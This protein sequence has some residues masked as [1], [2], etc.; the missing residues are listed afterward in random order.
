M[1]SNKYQKG[2]QVLAAFNTV[3]VIVMTIH[4]FMSDGR[5]ITRILVF[6]KY[7]ENKISV[8][9]FFFPKISYRLQQRTPKCG[10]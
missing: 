4:V 1:I 2:P 10:P 6:S 8:H 5:I 3:I 9:L 7:G